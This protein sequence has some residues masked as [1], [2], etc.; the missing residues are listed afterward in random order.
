LNER[1]LRRRERELS[2]DSRDGEGKRE[3][4]AYRWIL[5]VCDKDKVRE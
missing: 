4:E 1:E 3:E 2:E 5:G